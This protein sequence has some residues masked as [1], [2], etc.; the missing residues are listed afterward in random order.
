MISA[1]WHHKQRMIWIVSN[2]SIS[3]MQHVC[4]DVTASFHCIST[5]HAIGITKLEWLIR[6]V[7]QRFAGLAL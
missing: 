7:Q 6:S 1:V 2:V 4:W 5:M 3:Q